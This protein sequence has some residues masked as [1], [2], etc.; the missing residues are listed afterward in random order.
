MVFNCPGHFQIAAHVDRFAIDDVQ[1]RFAPNET[2][3][4]V[5][6]GPMSA[7][8]KMNPNDPSKWVELFS[9]D[10]DVTVRGFRLTKVSVVKDGLSVPLA[11]ASARLVKVADQQLNPDYPK[12]IPRG[13]TG[14][15]IL[16]P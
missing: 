7:T 12:S 10:K 11:D 6:I 5:E 9:P 2:F 14:K 13:G 4:L 16:I 8:C 3:K 15:A 1:L